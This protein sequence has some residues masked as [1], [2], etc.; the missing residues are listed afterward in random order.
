M[1]IIMPNIFRLSLILLLMSLGL[2]YADEPILINATI[3]L[4]AINLSPDTI[5][6]NTPFIIHIINKTGIPVELENSDTSTEMYTGL[7]KTFKIGLNK[8][9]YKFFNDFNPKTKTALLKV[10]T[11]AALAKT[12][13]VTSTDSDRAP[14]A[15]VAGAKLSEIIFIVWRE[16]IEALLVVGIV[17]SWIKHLKS[18]QKQAMLFLWMGVVIGLGCAALLGLFLVEMSSILSGTA[19]NLL[20]AS[21]TLV[22]ALMI[23]YMVKWMRSNGRTLKSEMLGAIEKNSGNKWNISIAVVVAIAIAREGS[24]AMIFIY[25]LGFGKQGS[26]SPIMLAA[27]GSGVVLALATMY[28]FQLCNK[29]FA[30]KYFFKV[31]EVL[32]LLLGGG[33]L[34]NCV[35]LLISSG[36]LPALHTKLWDSSFII[37]DGGHVAPMLASLIGYRSTPSLMDVVVYISYWIAI[38]VL[39]KQRLAAKG[40]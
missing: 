33:L 22:A 32:L 5:T 26:V 21:M 1:L 34:L 9:E 40:S 6:E 14:T 20:Q 39:F 30:W 29:I 27:L 35:D 38:Y 11:A 10:D 18:G 16:C 31:T 24:E 23:V 15:T 13:A 37:A 36:L 3:T 25:A 4:E 2:A 8:G 12:P 7:D 17:F 19:Q 28:L